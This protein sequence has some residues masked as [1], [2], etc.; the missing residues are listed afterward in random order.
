MT[1]EKAVTAKPYYDYFDEEWEAAIFKC[2]G[3]GW[4]GSHEEMSGPNMFNELMDFRCNGCYK[5]ILIVNYPTL[6]AMIREAKN[7][8]PSAQRELAIRSG[9]GEAFEEY[10]REVEEANQAL[11][12]AWVKFDGPKKLFM[13]GRRTLH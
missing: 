5:I 6:E 2:P 3:C 10:K 9:K 13:G 8:N 7:G 12:D 4:C 11:R 1:A